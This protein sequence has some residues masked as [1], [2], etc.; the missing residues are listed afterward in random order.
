MS[1]DFH[2]SVLGWDSADDDAGAFITAESPS[3]AA[4][5]YAERIDFAAYGRGKKQPDTRRVK[6]AGRTVTRPH[7]V[8]ACYAV[9]VV[10]QAALAAGLATADL[11][12]LTAPFVLV[13]WLFLL[14]RTGLRPA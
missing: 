8:G 1:Q 6:I 5:L 4:R 12:V 14:P 2:C 9:T 11:P 13:T 7:G 10:V 3:E